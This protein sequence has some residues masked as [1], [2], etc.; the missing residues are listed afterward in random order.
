MTGNGNGSGSA[1]SGGGVQDIDPRADDIGNNGVQDQGSDSGTGSGADTGGAS[2]GG[3]AAP[4]DPWTGTAPGFLSEKF[5][6]G[7]YAELQAKF[8]AAQQQAA[9]VEAYQELYRNQT[10]QEQPGPGQQQAQSAEAGGGKF[11]GFPSR[12]AY[13][14][15]YQADPVGTEEKKMV[16]LLA[17]S[18]GNVLSPALQRQLAPLQQQLVAQKAQANVQA[19]YAK[20]PEAKDASLYRTPAWNSFERANAEWI[21]ELERARP[22]LNARELA[23]KLFHYDTLRGELNALRAKHGEIQRGAGV[24]RSNVGSPAVN[25]ARPKNSAEAIRLAAEKLRGRGVSVPQEWVTA[26]ISN[27]QG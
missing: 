20:Y 27:L 23:F 3:G 25:A 5:G 10:Q 12:E 26:Q 13:I 19:V 1:V 4:P 11:F 21:S 8:E 18:Q 9:L 7:T 15:A 16:F 6:I 17:R 2:G 24:A 14:A 22:D